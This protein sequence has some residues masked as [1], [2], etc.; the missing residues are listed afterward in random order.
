M[1]A[2]AEHELEVRVSGEFVFVN[3]TRL[4]ID[5]ENYASFSRILAVF[6]EAGIGLCRIQPGASALDWVVLLSALQAGSSPPDERRVEVMGKLERAAV[7]TLEVGPPAHMEDEEFREKAKEAAKRTYAQSVSVTKDVINSTRMGK[8]PNLKKIKR[9]VQ[10]IVDQ[11]LN[12][13]TSRLGLTTLRDYDEYTF[14]HSVN[15]CIFSVALGRKLGLTRMQLYD[16]GMAAYPAGRVTQTIRVTP[17][18]GLS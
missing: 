10:G 17:Q 11:L 13:E 4:R 9:V 15:V 16:L 2:R 5:L 6:K 7:K 12:E 14:T 3:S 8:S 18:S 1:R